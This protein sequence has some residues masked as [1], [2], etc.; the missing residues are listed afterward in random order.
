MRPWRGVGIPIVGLELVLKGTDADLKQ[1]RCFRPV[2][3][4]LLQGP[5]NVAALHLAQR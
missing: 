3:M 4:S 2:A 5:E 1:S